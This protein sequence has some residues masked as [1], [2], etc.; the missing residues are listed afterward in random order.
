MDSFDC[1]SGD[2][3][4]AEAEAPAPAGYDA[5]SE[6]T[7]LD[8][9]EP[10]FRPGDGAHPRAPSTLEDGEANA[11]TGLP[12]E[13]PPRPGVVAPVEEG[14]P[15][16]ESIEG[17]VHLAFGT[18]D[19]SVREMLA[20]QL[21]ALLKNPATPVDDAVVEQALALITGIGPRDVTEA[22]L[23]LQMVAA[24]QA[25]MATARRA[26]AAPNANLA[27]F[28]LSLSGKLM[29]TFTGQLEALNRGRGK[30]IVQRVVV[31]RVNIE[32]GAQAVVGA[33]TAPGVGRTS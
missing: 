17:T 8:R 28:Y 9:D 18:D 20:S 15:P 31:E 29:R 26:L 23:A 25:A 27:G 3:A 30:G 10:G 22:M 7:Y 14:K 19:A 2:N 24:H 4:S 21:V 6:R 1:P 33:V 13:A 12:P 16:T 32:R 5:S 11:P